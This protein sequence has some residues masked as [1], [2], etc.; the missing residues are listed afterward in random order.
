MGLGDQLMYLLLLSLGVLQVY[1]REPVLISAEPALNLAIYS[2]NIDDFEGL[3]DV[4]PLGQNLNEVV[5]IIIKFAQEIIKKSGHATVKIPDVQEHFSKRIHHIKISGDFKA[6]NGFFK[7]LS[8]IRRT[9]DA[10]LSHSGD[11]VTVSVGLGMGTLEAGYDHYNVK[12]EHVSISGNIKAEVSSNSVFVKVN[13]V[14]LEKGKCNLTLQ[15]L[16]IELNGIE[17]HVGGKQKPVDWILSKIATS[18]AKHIKDD[19][20]REAEKRLR[21]AAQKALDKYHC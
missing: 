16:R 8:S 20:I 3:H 9:S 4:S 2:N 14:L 17:V 19:A 7:D 1:C 15:D 10:I 21:E 12:V 11:N 5:D 6:E 13:V 18:V